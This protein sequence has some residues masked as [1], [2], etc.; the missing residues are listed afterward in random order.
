MAVLKG[1]K[2][3]DVIYAGTGS[4][5]L[6]PGSDVILG[7]GNR[8]EFPEKVCKGLREIVI[9]VACAILICDK[10]HSGPTYESLQDVFNKKSFRPAFN[11]SSP[12][13]TNISFTLYAVLGV[14]WHHEFLQ[15]D[16]E[17]CGGVS[18]ISLPVEELWTPDII[19][20][21]FIDEDKSQRCPYVYVNHTG[22]IRYDRMLRVVS[23]CNLEIFN[24]PFDVQNCTLTFGSYM[25]T[26]RDVRVSTAIPFEQI[27]ANSK[28]YL[29][30]SGEWELVV[31]Q[32]ESDILKFGI[33]EWD[34]ITFWVVI[35]RRPILYVVN[36]LIPSAFLMVI[37]ILSFLLP[38]HSVDRASFKMTLI[39]GYTVF[40]L[41]MNDLL[42]STANGT[43]LIA[44]MVM[45]LLETVIITNILHHNAMKYEPVPDWVRVVFLNHIAR[46]ICYKHSPKPSE[47][48]STTG[49]FSNNELKPY[50]DPGEKIK[51]IEVPFIQLPSL[52][53]TEVQQI[54]RDL[55]SVRSHL[56]E[57]QIQQSREEEW[58]HV[59]Y[60]LDF[61]LFRV[62]LFF[63]LAYALV[64]ICT[65]CIWFNM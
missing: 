58:I 64:I 59:G 21:E 39:L 33:D 53:N 20:Y 28:K 62:Y 38:P 1:W 46:L 34:I 24:F 15:W 19:V 6:V 37:D 31:I 52:A 3:N 9:S 61:L 65:W 42:P 27:S 50:T 11:L 23:S 48:P 2:G 12:T 7:A 30:T 63:I 55:A 14:Y 29:E 57:L 5:V 32:G 13:I 18:K 56:D 41:I 51:N 25:H 47:T 22:Q 54:S 60:I 26:I 36:L 17:A 49:D 44:F 43:P 4:G 45:S 35:K 40:L 8:R 10:K 16:P